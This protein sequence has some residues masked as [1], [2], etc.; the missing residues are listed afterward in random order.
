MR[1][2]SS[3]TVDFCATSFLGSLL[4]WMT[5][6]GHAEMQSRQPLHAG[7]LI[8]TVSNSVRRIAPVGHTSRHGASW[9]CL[10]TSDIMSQAA[11]LRSSL[12]CSMNLT[13]RQFTSEKLRVLS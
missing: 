8:Y 3:Q 6:N 2:R 9:Q 13:C 10:Q 1:S 7:P 12:N 4:M 5:P 11:S